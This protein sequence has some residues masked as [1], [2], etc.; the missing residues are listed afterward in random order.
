MADRQTYRQV[1]RREKTERQQDIGG[2]VG[3][4]DRS[5]T[6]V[7][8]PGEVIYISVMT[9]HLK[10]QETLSSRTLSPLPLDVAPLPLPP[11]TCNF[12]VMFGNIGQGGT[13][14]GRTDR[15]EGRKERGWEEKD[16]DD[17]DGKGMM[18]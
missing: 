9:I 5:A 11:S 7:G 8:L 16:D 10:A 12:R 14:Y 13:E 17:D 18:L 1:G 2:G 4:C 3:G 6:T 15:R